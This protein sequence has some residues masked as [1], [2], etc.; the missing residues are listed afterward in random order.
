M[1]ETAPFGSWASPVTPALILEGAVSLQQVETSG[2]DVYWLEGRP[3]EAGRVVLVR[4]GDDVTPAGFSVRTRVH[5]YGGGAYTVA[6]D[7]VF[8]SN[9]TDQRL[10]RHDPGDSQ[11]PTDPQPITPEGPTRY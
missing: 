4:N 10:Y 11:E 7:R 1:A 5:E 3:Q 2:D 9:W 6:G 8:F